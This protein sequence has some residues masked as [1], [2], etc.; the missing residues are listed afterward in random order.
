M[1][2]SIVVFVLAFAAMGLLLGFAAYLDI[3]M[4]HPPAFLSN[5][6]MNNTSRVSVQENVSIAVQKA[7]GS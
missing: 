5:P 1:I 7:P 4:E 2:S 3:R 6:G